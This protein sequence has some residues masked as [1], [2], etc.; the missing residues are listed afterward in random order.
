MRQTQ[1]RLKEYGYC[2]RLKSSRNEEGSRKAAYDDAV[3]IKAQ[4]WCSVDKLKVEMYG[5][6]SARILNMLYDGD[7]EIKKGD[8]ICFNSKDK[9]DY[10]VVSDY[11]YNI[12]F[13]ELEEI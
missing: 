2:K 3:P 12:K 13:F 8:G 5:E 9:P 10:K 6:K 7:I 1:K 4:I 11:P